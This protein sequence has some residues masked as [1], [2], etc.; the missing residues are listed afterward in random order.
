ML[1]DIKQVQSAPITDLKLTHFVGLMTFTKDQFAQTFTTE[2]PAPAKVAEQL[3]RYLTAYTVLDNAYRADKYSLDTEKLKNADEAC[4]HIFMGIKKMTQAQQA[5]EFNLAVKVAADRMM[6]CIDKFEIDVAEDYLG[7]NNK[8]QQFLVEISGSA[9]LTADA[10]TLG[11]AD[12]LTQLDEQVTLLRDLLTQR[13]NAKPSKGAMKAARVNME[14]EYRWLIAILNAAA[15]MNNDEHAYETLVNTL[16]N[17]IDYLRVHALKDGGATEGGGGTNENEN[18]GG[19]TN[20]NDNENDNGGTDSNQNQG[21]STTPT[22]PDTP[23]DPGTGGGSG[24]G[25]SEVEE[26]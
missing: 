5:F 18:G 24:G 8:L 19:G 25:S 11:L 2:N 7:E 3:S 10:Q 15:L 16:N 14:P 1:Q 20:E 26:G 6:Q 23:S 13:G 21:G 22:T 12:A 9:Q 17:N 4:D